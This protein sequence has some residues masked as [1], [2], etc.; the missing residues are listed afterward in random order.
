MKDSDDYKNAP[1]EQKKMMDA[2]LATMELSMTFTDD[3]IKMTTKM[4]EESK[5]QEG[6]YT[7]KSSEGNKITIEGEMDGKKEELV[8]TI[9]GDSMT[10]E[11][12]GKKMTFKRE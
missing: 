2:M 7:I 11:D 4:G 10:T 9:D 1:D 3:T 8:F 5:D 6:K 12:E